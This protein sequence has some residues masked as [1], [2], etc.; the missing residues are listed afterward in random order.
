MKACGLVL[1]HTPVDTNVHAH[2]QS[3]YIDTTLTVQILLSLYYIGYECNY[4]P[5]DN[6]HQNKKSQSL[7]QP[8][9]SP[10][11]FQLYSNV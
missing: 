9:K 1:I 7:T 8:R 10:K 11:P 2:T 4:N 3:V 6:N 5:G